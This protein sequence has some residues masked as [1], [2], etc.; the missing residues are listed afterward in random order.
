MRLLFSFLLFF[1]LK[2]SLAAETHCNLA[3]NQI[4]EAKLTQQEKFRLDA[5]NS[6]GDDLL[7]LHDIQ[8]SKK[9]SGDALRRL[10]KCVEQKQKAF[11][12]HESSLTEGG[13]AQLL[14]HIA[15]AKL[16]YSK[17]DYAE[18]T[19]R[20]KTALDLKPEDFRILVEYFDS[21]RKWR[22]HILEKENLNIIE[23][24]SFK[25]DV[26]NILQ[27]V[28]THPNATTK[29]RIEAHF[30]LHDD[31]L[32]FKQEA[33]AMEELRSVLE[34]D[35]KN[36]IALSRLIN[37]EIRRGRPK[38]A[39]AYLETL[40][41][42]HE[43]SPDTFTKL[44]D[45]ELYQ[46]AY[47]D[48]LSTSQDALKL[49][50]QNSAVQAL[51]ASALAMNNQIREAEKILSKFSQSDRALPQYK[52]AQ[53]RILEKSGDESRKMDL[54]GKALSEYKRGLDLSPERLGLR[55]KMADLIYT[56]RSEKNFEPPAVALE[57]MTEVT[58]L[59]SPALQ[60]EPRRED[61]VLLYLEASPRSKNPAQA[62][63]LCKDLEIENKG[64]PTANS[65]INCAK[66]YL[67]Q[68]SKGDAKRLLESALFESRFSA[69]K[70]RLQTEYNKIK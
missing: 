43:P 7:N 48:A 30:A 22:K 57:E 47:E 50:P 45:I 9:L 29:A 36:E 32:V 65:V 58:R 61:V 19:L 62:L 34:L 63:S 35:P 26:R 17:E 69:F 40:L 60:S 38:I 49:F 3:V 23:V 24:E 15:S 14:F 59:L 18:S 54:P 20:L 42:T 11:D 1:S 37:F 25:K 13:K 21:W 8:K 51:R 5:L 12:I 33:P 4:Q 28:L 27:K 56:Y 68:K 64:F 53:S 44:L 39:K 70:D 55:I 46:E 16:A 31:F 52:E 6:L 41:K 10:L 67:L 66:I 2:S